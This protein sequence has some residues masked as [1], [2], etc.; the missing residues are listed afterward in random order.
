MHGRVRRNADERIRALEREVLRGDLSAVQALA[1][2][3]ELAGRKQVVWEVEL[4][5]NV[6]DA[7]YFAHFAL[8]AT[9]LGAVN[10]LGSHLR[11][12]IDQGFYDQGFYGG[13]RQDAFNAFSAMIERG[14]VDQAAEAHMRYVHSLNP[15]S[16]D[17]IEAS[18]ECAIR[19]RSIEP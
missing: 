9:R 7:P 3:Y 5:V 18:N 13:M 19:E 2:A 1:R 6:P 8:H 11:W 14:E 4:E 15:H 12:L 17:D 16:P 10:D